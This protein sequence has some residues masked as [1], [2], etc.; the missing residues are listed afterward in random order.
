MEDRTNSC[1]REIDRQVDRGR[2]T[3][4]EREGERENEAEQINA[5]HTPTHI[6]TAAP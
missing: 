2:D 6:L 1:Y 5:M 3:E 4:G